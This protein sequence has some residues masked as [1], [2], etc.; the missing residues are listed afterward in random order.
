MRKALAK[1]THCWNCRIEHIFDFHT[2]KVLKTFEV[3]FV[4]KSNSENSEILHLTFQIYFPYIWRMNSK[5]LIVVVVVAL[6]FLGISLEQTA[7]PNQEIVVQ[8][9]A[10]SV[11]AT[12]TET[13]I[14]LVMKQLQSIGVE[15][16]D[17][18][19]TR[20]GNL[21]ITYYSTLDVAVVKDLFSKQAHLDLGYSTL[22]ANGETPNLPLTTDTTYELNVS[23]IQTPADAAMGFNGALVEIKSGNEW[24][25]NPVFYFGNAKVDLTLQ[26]NFY[27]ATRTQYETVALGIDTTSYKI[28]EVRAGPLS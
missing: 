26:N 16:I 9:N 28:P 1:P 22:Y 6:A 8:F 24:Y 4:I 11:S 18:A 7:T 15:S 10:D 2:S 19:K 13:A 3:F 17:I 23:E 12:E 5:W 27:N 20:N 21:K 25:V 14:A